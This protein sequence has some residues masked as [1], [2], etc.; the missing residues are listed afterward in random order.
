MTRRERGIAAYAKIFDVPE[1]DLAAA[2][3]ER[4]GTVIA[5]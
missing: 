5:A 3:A 4:V 1:D 2:F